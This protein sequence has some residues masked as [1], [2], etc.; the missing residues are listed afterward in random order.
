[1]DL[2]VLVIAKN[3]R[4]QVF[5]TQVLLQVQVFAQL[6]QMLQVQKFAQLA[7]MLQVFAQLVQ[8]VQ[9]AQVLQQL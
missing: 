3:D 7:Q 8:Q 1:L 4:E 6:A 9:L 5:V 2:L